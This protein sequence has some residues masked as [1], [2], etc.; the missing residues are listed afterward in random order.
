MKLI[1]TG[2]TYKVKVENN[3]QKQYYDFSISAKKYD[4]KSKNFQ[5][6][7]F[8]NKEI[9]IEFVK[10]Q[11]A[12]TLLFSYA[13]FII[14]TIVKVAV[15]VFLYYFMNI[16]FYYNTSMVYTSICLIAILFFPHF[17]Y[18]AF[19]GNKN[20]RDYTAVI[21]NAFMMIAVLLLLLFACF[22]ECLKKKKT[23]IAVIIYPVIILFTYIP[24]SL[25]FF[26]IKRYLSIYMWI[27]LFMNEYYY[28]HKNFNFNHGVKMAYFW[29]ATYSFEDILPYYLWADNIVVIIDK[30]I[31]L[32]VI[33]LNVGAHM[34]LAVFRV[35]RDFHDAKTSL[36]NS[37]ICYRNTLGDKE[38]IP[39]THLSIMDSRIVNSVFR[40][41]RKSLSSFNYSLDKL[42]RSSNP[43]NI[44]RRDKIVSRGAWFSIENT[45]IYND[46]EMKFD[47][48]FIY[49]LRNI[50]KEKLQEM[51]ITQAKKYCIKFQVCDYVH[52]SQRKMSIR[53][54]RIYNVN[55]DII[56][57]RAAEKYKIFN[58]RTR[59]VIRNQYA[60]RLLG[61]F[62]F[63]TVADTQNDWYHFLSHKKFILQGT[64]L[65][66][67]SIK[68]ATVSEMKGSDNNT[69]V[70]KLYAR[71]TNRFTLWQSK[72]P[73]TL[74]VVEDITKNT[75]T[76]ET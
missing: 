3:K 33:G 50:K 48:N 22:Y 66:A 31:L 36:I 13:I 70:S 64:N 2:K 34:A 59:K 55:R 10:S 39:C 16:Y 62:C 1:G 35:V 11:K 21:S 76:Q 74:Y 49:L 32:K 40:P 41:L 8:T 4:M 63:N 29:M 17:L 43:P 15:I 23:P 52:I 71:D 68:L 27:A 56:L 38:Q 24:I 46:V 54:D 65:K 67:I 37:Q 19:L 12:K 42:D 47:C 28:K 69:K 60:G 26:P 75:V 18:F 30:S 6:L 45:R 73:M 20:W 53:L 61:E 58:S 72:C 44:L 25:I 14:F 5:D 51:D 57:V 7:K 9:E